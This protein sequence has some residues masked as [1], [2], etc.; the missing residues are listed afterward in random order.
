MAREGN[1]TI[2][3]NQAKAHFLGYDQKALVRKL[4]LQTDE[5]WL[6]TSL[7]G[8]PYRIHRENGSIERL[9]RGCWQDANSY[10]E[11]MTLLDL[12][13]DSREDRHPSGQWQSMESF[14]HQFHRSLL[15]DGT[16]P[17]A[18][19]FAADVEGFSR[20]CEALGGKPL[21]QGDAAYA[22]GVFEGLRVGIQLWIGDEEF[23]SRLKIMWDSNALQY[24]RYETMYFAKAVLLRLLREGLDRQ[25]GQLV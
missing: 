1:Y 19:R 11:I 20:A 10:E 3:A 8:V 5:R 18:E 4:N 9:R 16:D 25:D 24:L 7:F 15:E 14:G 2:Q 22:I 23:P 17:W 6:Y 12:V 13:C 21:P